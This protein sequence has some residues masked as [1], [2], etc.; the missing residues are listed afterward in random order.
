VQAVGEIVD[1]IIVMPDAGAPR[2]SGN[3]RLAGL[4]TWPVRGFEN[5]RISYLVR[6]DVL[7]IV[8]VVHGRRDIGAVFEGQDVENLNV[9]RLSQRI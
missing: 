7:Q 9:R 6:S 3:R 8:R 5:I 4:H 1:T 2:E